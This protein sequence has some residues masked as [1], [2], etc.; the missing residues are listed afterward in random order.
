MSTK[1]KNT[2]SIV[3]PVY[4][5]EEIIKISIDRILKLRQKIKD[6]VNTEVI[7]VM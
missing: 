7:F 1:N 5:E 2:L 6:K 4:N 3:L